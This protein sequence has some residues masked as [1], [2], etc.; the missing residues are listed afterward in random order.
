MKKN[1]IANYEKAMKQAE[2]KYQANNSVKN[3]KIKLDRE[4]SKLQKGYQSQKI[5]KSQAN[6]ITKTPTAKI[7]QSMAQAQKARMASAISKPIMTTSK[8]G[9][10]KPQKTIM[11]AGTKTTVSK[12]PGSPKPPKMKMF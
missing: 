7:K 11:S 9:V 4:M 1:A 3:T 2:R 12:M 5:G 10:T 8:M 6:L